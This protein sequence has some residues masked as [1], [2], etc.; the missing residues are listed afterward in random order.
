MP[1]KE[2]EGGREGMLRGFWR[3][4]EEVFAAKWESPEMVQMHKT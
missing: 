2:G 1:W 3:R 4:G